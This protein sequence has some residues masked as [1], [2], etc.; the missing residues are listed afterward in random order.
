MSLLSFYKSNI[1]FSQLSKLQVCYLPIF[2]NHN[3]FNHIYGVSSC[4]KQSVSVSHSL[5]LTTKNPIIVSKQNS[6][7]SFSNNQSQFAIS[8]FYYYKGFNNLCSL[9]L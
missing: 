2:Y 5:S 8:S 9:F 1:H 7:L 3:S 6:N 4:S